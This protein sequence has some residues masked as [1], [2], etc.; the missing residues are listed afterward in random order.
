MI[1]ACIQYGLYVLRHKWFVFL[2][3]CRMGHPLL[4]L[5]HD[6]SKFRPSEFIPYARHFYGPNAKQRRDKTGY[7]KPTDTGD[8]AFDE[9]WFWHQKRNKHHWSYWVTP[10]HGGM[11]AMEMPWKYVEEMVADWTGAGMAQG[12]PDT[13]AWY[14]ANGGKMVLHDKTRARVENLLGL[15]MPETTGLRQKWGLS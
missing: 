3:A 6:C 14:R 12:K 2:A 13:L 10:D 11:K 1:R 5:L 9:A 15:P 4:G 7:Y 8:P